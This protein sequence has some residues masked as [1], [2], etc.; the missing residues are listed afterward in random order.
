MKLG[1][2]PK[3]MAIL[4]GLVLAG[5][6]SFYSNVIS[7]PDEP[8]EART[9]APAPAPAGRAAAA[10]G[11]AP[12]PPRQRTSSRMQARGQEFRPSLKWNP[13]EKLD[14]MSIDPTL[15]LDLL[16]KVQAVDMQGGE[17]NLFQFSTA[18]PPPAPKDV[19][20]IVPKTPAQAALEKAKEKAK[21]DPVKA[22][23]PPINLKYFGYST[24]H[25]SDRKSA[26]FLDG[27]DIVVGHEGELVKHRYRVV[28]IGVTS[29]VMEDTTSKHEQTLPLVEDIAG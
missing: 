25:G 19:P 12:A 21:S 23:A 4:G 27:D 15:R 29:V 3:K 10:P 16:A 8:P 20:K 22:A 6:Y 5:A 14:P 2:E 9:A 1:A 13:E 28:K 24:Q 7:S 17:R 26:F 11:V 18:P